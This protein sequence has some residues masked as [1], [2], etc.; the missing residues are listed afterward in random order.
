MMKKIEKKTEAFIGRYSMIDENDVIVAGVSGGA[1]SVCLLFVLCALRKK[2]GFRV[3]VCHVNHG[4]RGKAADE[5]EKYVKKL[6]EDLGVPCR[7]FHEDVE[8][9]AR[10]G[11][12]SLEEAGRLVRRRAFETMCREN[13]G[14][15]IATAHH[16]DDNAETVLLNIA[17]G[18]GIRGLCGIRPVYGRWIR[19]LLCL[20]REEIEDGLRAQ[21][22]SWC[23][24]ATNDEDEYTRNRIRHHIIPILKEQVNE[25]TVRHIGQLS[26]QAGEIWD[27][28]QSQVEAAW[29]ICVC[30]ERT[31]ETDRIT[32][33][34]ETFERVAPAVQK[35]LVHRCISAAAGTER[36]I[37]AVHVEAV[38]DLFKK[39]TGRSRNLCGGVTALRT[40]GA[41][42]LQRM[43]A[44]KREC[45][46][47]K[48]GWEKQSCEEQNRENVPPEGPQWQVDL[49]IPGETY[50]P[51]TGEWILCRFAEEADFFSAKEIPQKSYTKLFDYDII[52]YSL[53]ARTR[54]AGDYFTVDAQ[55][56]RQ[57]LKSYFINEKVPHRERDRMLL[58]ADGDHIIWIPGMRMS[59]AYRVREE[60]K[61]I[62]EIKITKEKKDG[63]DDQGADSG[64]QSG[65]ENQ[66]TGRTDQ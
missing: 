27:Y 22:I 14:T 64:R 6:C 62:L 56:K 11:K 42:E 30:E 28:M 45:S 9:T 1:D 53:S 59:S 36:N 40:Y 47:E 35:L 43:P 21:G 18:T 2:M 17:R 50:F 51:E 25:G 61:K 46:A 32:I 55:G 24:D 34:G 66:G 33:H 13:G 7:V 16:R 4:I 10:N 20:S 60:T 39:Q 29:K 58:I 19:P 54:R 48:S 12:Y 26:R 38:L 5:D 57:K 44:Q 37:E 49:N 3:E 31:E 15:K 23:T 52:K 65:S 8:L 63:R 41:V